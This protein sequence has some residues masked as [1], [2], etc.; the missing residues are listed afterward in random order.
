MHELD[1]RYL[2]EVATF[3]AVVEAGGFAPASHVLNR[4]PTVLS[5]RVTALERR[6]GV[7]L[8]ERT[9]RS[10]V[11]TEAGSRFAARMRA[12][13]AVM[14]EAQAEAMQGAVIPSGTLRLALPGAFGRAWI[15]PLLPAFLAA[16][17]AM[18]IDVSYSDRYVDLVADGY[19]LAV[20]IGALPDSRLVVRKLADN[21][22]LVCAAPSYLAARGAPAV[23]ADLARHN[24]LQ[25]TR[26]AAFPDWSLRRDGKTVAVKTTGNVRADDAESLVPFAV[27]GFGLL[28]CSRWLV[29]AELADGRLVPVLA[30]WSVEG[31]GGIHLVRPSAQ[32]TTAKVRAFSAWLV[33]RMAEPPWR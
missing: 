7:R 26:H 28:L 2:S 31:E 3:L 6:L 4:D 11:L 32:F 30:D 17:P 20:R 10:V 29:G 33:E 21:R 15:A 14:G 12:A 22:R 1:G 27:G 23:P 13:L 8:V 16:H 25:F 19:D 24:C 9:T 5:R 18:A